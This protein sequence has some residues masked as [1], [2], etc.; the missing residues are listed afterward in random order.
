MRTPSKFGSPISVFAN[1][2]PNSICTSSTKFLGT[3]ILLTA[4]H[5]CPAF[6]VISFV[7]SFTNNSNSGVP[8]T[9]SGPKTLALRE[10]ASKLKGTDSEITFG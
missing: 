6:T 4:V 7:T 5:F 9:A 2:F 8:G 10:S 3:I 1:L